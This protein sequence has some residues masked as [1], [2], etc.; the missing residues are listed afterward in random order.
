MSVG[1][2]IMAGG[3]SERMRSRGAP[4]HKALV[5]ILGQNLLERNACML[6]GAGFRFATVSVAS[7]EQSIVDF[8]DEVL[9]DR[10]HAFG[11]EIVSFVEQEPLGTIGAARQLANRFTS[12]LVVNVDNLTSMDFNEFVEWHE[13]TNADMT[14]AT[15][16]ESF[17]IPF[18]ELEISEQRVQ[19]C[20][21]KSIRSIPISSGSYVL[22]ERA[23]DQIA[24][25]GRT[26]AP[27][28]VNR[29]IKDG[30]HVSAFE[31]QDLWIDVNDQVALHRAEELLK[32]HSNNF[33]HWTDSPHDEVVLLR[34]DSGGKVLL[35]SDSVQDQDMWSLPAMSVGDIDK[36]A[37]IWNGL[38]VASETSFDSISSI[39]PRITRCHVYRGQIDSSIAE[40]AFAT[41]GT[42]RSVDELD[43]DCVLPTTLR[44]LRLSD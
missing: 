16:V 10:F 42:F 38:H 8:V 9:V 6:L 29:L 11:G 23:L 3:R 19:R 12:V 34:I 2:M 32:Q 43:G 25:T 24:A 41:D 22:G 13:S 7:G 21:E 18:G 37:L 33:E 27:D 30:A 1:V 14:I 39:A 15:H 20:I 26:D 5:S 36:G 44:A 4:T 28:L 40:A 17:Q 35:K 31:H